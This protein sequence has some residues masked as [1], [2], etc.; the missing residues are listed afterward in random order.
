[1]RVIWG[2]TFDPV[3]NGHIELAHQL[4]NTLGL[5]ELYLMP[6]YKA[7]HKVNVSAS[8]SQRLQMLVMATK[9]YPKLRI[10][11]RE[12]KKQCASYTY[13]SLCDIRQEIGREP[14]SFVM[15][16]DALINFPSWY[17]AKNLHKL[18]NIIIVQRPDCSID[19]VE[20]FDKLVDDSVRELNEIG[21]SLVD[22]HHSLTR[23]ESGKCL[24]LKLTEI[25]VSSSHIRDL[26]KQHKKITHLVD[27]EVN[28][29]ISMHNLYLK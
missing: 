15:G 25:N 24:K 29:F 11:D 3:H 18:T 21:F 2:G 12:I 5:D 22:E 16:T 26:V 8:P 6:C 14:L 20:N 9:K 1:M 19:S 13:E 17:R 23:Y 4:V 7:V 28:H 10:D 27:S